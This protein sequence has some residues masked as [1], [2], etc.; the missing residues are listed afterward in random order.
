MSESVDEGD[1]VY[2]LINPYTFNFSGE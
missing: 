1:K 2:R